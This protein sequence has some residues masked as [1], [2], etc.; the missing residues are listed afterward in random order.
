MGLTGVAPGNA[1][2]VVFI[3]AVRDDKSGGVGM[4]TEVSSTTSLSASRRGSLCAQ[5][6]AVSCKAPE[7][8]S[9]HYD[10]MKAGRSL[11][12]A[13]FDQRAH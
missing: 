1:G 10:Y 6:A 3:R 9:L 8:R 4:Q 12:H 5:E 7:C 13:N 11:H 2:E